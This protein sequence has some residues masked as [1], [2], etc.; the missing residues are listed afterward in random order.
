MIKKKTD[1]RAT[2]VVNMLIGLG[3]QHRRI[4]VEAAENRRLKMNQ[5]IRLIIWE[6]YERIEKPRKGNKD[7]RT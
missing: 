3:A 4:V 1:V 5:M 6:W 2:P 7:G